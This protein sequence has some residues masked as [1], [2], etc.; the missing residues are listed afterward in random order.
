MP[1]LPEDIKQ[2]DES[3]F[4]V[5]GRKYDSDPATEPDALISIVVPLKN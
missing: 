2:I 4:K 3:G 1:A 5:A